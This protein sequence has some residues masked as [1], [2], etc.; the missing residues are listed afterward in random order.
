MFKYVIDRE[1][2]KNKNKF[3]QGREEGTW[4]SKLYLY[5]KFYKRF[6]TFIGFKTLGTFIRS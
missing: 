1:D 4:G 5:P 3:L 6:L 2:T